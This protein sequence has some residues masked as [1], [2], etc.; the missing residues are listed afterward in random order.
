MFVLHIK[1]KLDDDSL[2]LYGFDSIILI[3]VSEAVQKRKD[4][5]THPVTVDA[6]ALD[7]R[8]LQTC[9]TKTR[10]LPLI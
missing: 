7:P 3:S 6:H 8:F 2:K 4:R 1:A 10:K 9:L 5:N